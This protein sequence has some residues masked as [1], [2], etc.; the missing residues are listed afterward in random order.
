MTLKEAIVEAGNLRNRIINRRGLIN[1][2]CHTAIDIHAV[3]IGEDDYD[4]IVVLSSTPLGQ[5]TI[6]VE[7]FL[8]LESC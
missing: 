8:S 6:S 2:I 4:V 3:P 7:E 5:T 1:N